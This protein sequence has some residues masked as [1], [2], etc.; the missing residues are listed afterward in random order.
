[1][2]IY[3]I[4]F[5]KKSAKKFFN[6]LQNNGI[7]RLIDIRL[8]PK[9]QLAG[10]TKQEDI[11][12]FLLTLIACEY[13]HM[14][15]LAPTKEILSEYRENKNWN[16]YEYKFEKLMGERRIPQSLDRN[17]FEVKTCCLLCSESEP[18]KCHRRLVAERLATHWSSTEIIHII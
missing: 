6:L 12:F 10:F 18:E 14:I 13:H 15:L 8:N 1:M 2:R 5:A 4:G 9:G 16:N 7:E 3:T 11:S 17:F